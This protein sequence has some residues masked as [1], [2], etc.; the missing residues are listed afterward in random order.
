[1]TIRTTR[2]LG[3]SALLPVLDP[4]NREWFTRGVITIQRCSDCEALQHPPDEHCGACQGSDLHWRECA[5]G[6]RVESV[7]VVHQAVHPAFKISVPYAVVVV[8]LDDA[9]GIN[10]IGNVVNCDP[11]DIEIGQR[12][13]AVF[14]EI[15][16]TDDRERMLVP[17]WEVV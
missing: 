12:V 16:P 14:E 3:E 11:Q 17:Q 4:L 10:A 13:R 2:T 8:S 6:G 5:G 15:E 9:P 1:M 7:A